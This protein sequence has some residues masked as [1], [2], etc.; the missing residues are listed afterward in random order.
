MV[1]ALLVMNPMTY[2]TAVSTC[3]TEHAGAGLVL[4]NTITYDAAISACDSCGE[5]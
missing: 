4:M 5:W 3:V 1:Q 2:R